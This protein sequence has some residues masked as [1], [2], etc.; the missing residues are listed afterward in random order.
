M[1]QQKGPIGPIRLKFSLFLRYFV[2]FFRFLPCYNPF[3]IQRMPSPLF[4]GIA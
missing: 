3:E 4:A 1:M 2:L